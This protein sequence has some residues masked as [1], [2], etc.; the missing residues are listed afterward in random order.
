[1]KHFGII[2]KKFNYIKVYAKIK[3]FSIKISPNGE[4]MEIFDTND[5][6]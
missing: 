5:I 6:P 2:E 3:T 1:M 4:G